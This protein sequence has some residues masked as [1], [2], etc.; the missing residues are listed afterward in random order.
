MTRN[1]IIQGDCVRV[2]NRLPPHSADLVFADPPYNLQLDGELRRPDASRVNGVDA[3]WDKFADF[4][5]YDRFTRAW[6]GAARRVLK[7]SGSLWVIGSYHN[8]FRIGAILQ[9]LEY[10]ILNDVV[11][12]KSNPMPNFR[13]TRF[14]NAHETL[15]WA[16]RGKTNRYTFN[17]HALKIF[18]ED[19]QMRSDWILPLC[20]GAERLK[21][22]AGD[23]LHPAQKPEA[24]LYRILLASSKVGDMVL[25]PFFGTGTTGAVAKRLRRQYIG[26]EREADYIQAARTRLRKVKPTQEEDLFLTPSARETRIPFGVLLEQG[27][28]APGIR[29]YSPRRRHSARLRA[30]GSLVCDNKT[31][32]IHSLGARIQGSATCNG[33]DFWHFQNAQGSLQPIN[34]LRQQILA[35]AI[36]ETTAH[37]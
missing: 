26:I 10:W 6:L 23:K 1:R 13:G 18:N 19:A 4:E 27:L 35:N 8:I 14:T 33:W 37:P 29:L 17:Y 11:W 7:P 32:S 36:Q 3:V 16:S 20:A 31:G 25:D 21:T 12:R 28:L 24:L 15:I 9:D 5:E 22:A 34:L 2:M 30:D